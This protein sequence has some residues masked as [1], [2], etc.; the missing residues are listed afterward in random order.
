MKRF[1][2]VFFAA[3][4]LAAS[5]AAQ[6]V[7][8]NVILRTNH[9]DGIYAKGDTVKVWADVKTVPAKPVVFKVMRWTQWDAE[10]VSEISLH[11]GENP[12][13][14]RMCSCME[15]RI[16]T[17]GQSPSVHHSPRVRRLASQRSA[18]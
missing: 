2:T 6:Q 4:V 15:C 11:E 1:I 12:L 18:W 14:C 8:D 9:E 13:F 17:S 5:V 7:R 16:L 10:S 3:L